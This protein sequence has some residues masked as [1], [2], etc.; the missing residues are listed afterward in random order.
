MANEFQSFHPNPTY[1]HEVFKLIERPSVGY[2]S[3]NLALWSEEYRSFEV[4]RESDENTHYIIKPLD[5]SPTPVRLRGSFT[6]KHRAKQQIDDYLKI[7]L[8]ENE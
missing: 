7:L 4:C 3:A 1:K 8:R 5:G 2:P 6:A